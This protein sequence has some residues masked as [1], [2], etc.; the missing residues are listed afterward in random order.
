[1]WEIKNNSDYP[2]EYKTKYSAGA[3]L[4]NNDSDFSLA[5]LERKLVGTGIFIE[6]MFNN[7]YEAQIRPR[8]G[9]AYKKG[10]TVHNAPGTIDADYRDEIK[11]LLI[12]L[13]NEHVLV[14]KGERIAQIVFAKIV[15][16]IT[17]EI[18][19]NKREG[20]FGSTGEK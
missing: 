12:N 1:M 14:E 20:G 4:Y 18:S 9:L 16:P 5:P 10:I 2:L 8:S 17:I 7:S 6:S 11:V 19:E 15:K 3:D 13:S